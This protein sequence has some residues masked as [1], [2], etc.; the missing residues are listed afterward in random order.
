MVEQNDNNNNTFSIKSANDSNYKQIVLD[1]YDSTREVILSATISKLEKSKVLAA[2]QSTK[3]VAGL[4]I[5]YVSNNQDNSKDLKSS[6]L[7]NLAELDD[8][9]QNIYT[10][11]ISSRYE[12][13]DKCTS[14]LNSLTPLFTY[15][16]LYVRRTR[17]ADFGFVDK[18][19]DK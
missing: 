16:G 3:L 9:A 18:K 10:S 1:H 19:V 12:I 13:I 15:I 11:G 2:Y 5:P 4:V 14:V 7:T 8:L 6:I 17:S